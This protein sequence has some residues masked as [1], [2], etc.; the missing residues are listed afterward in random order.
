[1]AR[2]QQQ[3]TK[4]PLWELTDEAARCKEN[5]TFVMFG[6]PIYHFFA[7]ST[8]NCR[9]AWSRF[10]N[11]GI[12]CLLL[13]LMT[14]KRSA[15]WRR[16][17]WKRQHENGTLFA[18]IILR[19]KI[20]PWSKWRLDAGR[21]SV[22]GSAKHSYHKLSQKLDCS[23]FYA[24]NALLPVQIICIKISF[25]PLIYFHTKCKYHAVKKKHSSPFFHCKPA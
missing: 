22:T 5:D 16:E 13:M 2:K 6:W 8:G 25:N 11:V 23:G 12:C 10:W 1:M 15:L 14:V 4:I 7:L 20:N 19:L 24:T 17:G 3:N 18:L 21:Q 9:L